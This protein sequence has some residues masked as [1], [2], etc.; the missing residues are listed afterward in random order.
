[1]MED[2]PDFRKLTPAEKV[3]FWFILSE[4]NLRGKFHKSDLETAV[5]VGI[6]EDKTRRA[7]RKLAKLG[8]L[9]ITPGFIGKKGRKFTTAYNMVKWAKPRKE[10]FFAMAHRYT[11]EA[12]L[13]QL[14]RGALAHADLVVYEYLTYFQQ[15]CQGDK[16]YFFVTKRELVELTGIP[17]A[18]RSV[19]TLYRNFVFTGGAHLFEVQDNYH[20]LT[21]SKWSVCSDPSEN[22]N[23]RERAE[24]YRREIQDQVAAIRSQK[25]QGGGSRMTGPDIL[26]TVYQH[27]AGPGY[28]LGRHQ[29][30]RLVHLAEKYGVKK[31]QRDIQAYFRGETDPCFRSFSY[32]EKW[33]KQ[34][35]G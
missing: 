20:K 13:A 33:F 16:E 26:I 35:N 12:L 2:T 9:E 28:R 3:Y 5:T 21:F 6:S 29:R 31:I 23:N 22:D 30:A 18:T 1:M 7:R 4:Y 11:F 34:Q 25:E 14:R 10:D 24:E 32:F 15:K 27:L 19:D 8:W 17:T